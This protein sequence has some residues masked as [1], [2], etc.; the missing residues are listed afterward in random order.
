METDNYDRG[1]IWRYGDFAEQDY[2]ERRLVYYSVYK[3]LICSDDQHRWGLLPIHGHR[4]ML[5][6]TIIYCLIIGFTVY[7]SFD[8][9]IYHHVTSSRHVTVADR[10]KRKQDHRKKPLLRLHLIELA[11]HDLYGTIQCI[12]QPVLACIA[13]CFVGDDVSKKAASLE[14]ELLCERYKQ[15]ETLVVLEL[16]LWKAACFLNAPAYVNADS[17]LAY[18]FRD[19]WKNNKTASRHDPLIGSV[20]ANVLNFLEL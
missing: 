20:I 8:G 5:C 4:I 19:G 12:P 18:F 15:Q 9:K 1:C 13:Q 6:F 10:S 11:V 16:A 17:M 14:L 3:F 2:P 7:D